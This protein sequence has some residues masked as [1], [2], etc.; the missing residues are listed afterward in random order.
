MAIIINL[1]YIAQF[2]NN[3]IL[4]VLYRVIKYMYTNAVYAHMDIHKTI[5]FIHIYMSTHISIHRHTH[6]YIYIYFRTICGRL[7]R[8]QA[9][10]MWTFPWTTVPP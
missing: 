3:S 10:H 1:T 6:I 9:E 2:D 8:D 7:L 5:M 4:T